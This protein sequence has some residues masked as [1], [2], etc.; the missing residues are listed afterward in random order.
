MY[1]YIKFYQSPLLF[2]FCCYTKQIKLEVGFL[3]VKFL[4][5]WSYE[6]IENP[7]QEFDLKDSKD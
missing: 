5:N 4:V 2:L 6:K 7:L 3:T 1:R